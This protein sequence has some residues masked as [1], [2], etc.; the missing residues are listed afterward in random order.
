MQVTF[1]RI[2]LGDGRRTAAGWLIKS[3]GV[4]R[5]IMSADTD[6]CVH[7]GFACDR[8]IAPVDGYMCFRDLAEAQAWI[9]DRFASRRCPPPAGT[10]RRLSWTAPDDVK[11]RRDVRPAAAAPESQNDD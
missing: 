5:G 3:D 4:L 11:A 10:P 6:G 8:R 7:F 2:R 9:L 1:D